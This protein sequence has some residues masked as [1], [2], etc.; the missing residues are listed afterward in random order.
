MYKNMP[1]GALSTLLRSGHEDLDWLTRLKIGIGA[2]RGLAWLHHGFEN[3]YLHQNL[4]SSA[5]L[6]DEDY[7]P[8]LTDFCLA[9]LVKTSTGSNNSNSN[10]STSPFMN[11]DFGDFGYV[12]PEYATTPV[13]TTKGDVYAFGV[14]LLELATGQ[15][16]T[17]INTDAAGEVFKGSLVDWVNQ[18]VNAGRISDAIDRSIRRKGYDD[19]IIQC[20]TIA[21]NCVVARPKERP[22]MYKVYNSLKSV[23]KGRETDEFDEFPLN[24][25]KD[26]AEA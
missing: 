22:F 20:L 13:A 15:K 4:S 25:G 18:L 2:A 12:A 17:E 7:D 19:E 1:G 14:V 21:C 8:R 11:G 24:F 3:P 23:G 9:R 10:S 6:L 5:V 16:P 26:D